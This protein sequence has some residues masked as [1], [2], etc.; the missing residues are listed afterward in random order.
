MVIINVLRRIYQIIKNLSNFPTCA[1]IVIN[2]YKV[3]PSAILERFHIQQNHEFCKPCKETCMVIT[4]EFRL[5]WDKKTDF[6]AS[7][8]KSS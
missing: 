6:E 4:S 1:D 5:R 2:P 3:H 7:S 8:L